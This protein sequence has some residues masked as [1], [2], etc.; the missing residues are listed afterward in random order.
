MNT[1]RFQDPVWLWLLIPVIAIG[2]LSM[3]REKR[4]AVLYSNVNLLRGLPV[5]LAQRLKRFLPWLRI[6]GMVLIVLA[7]A[8]PQS[9]REEFR[10]RTEGIAIEMCI[11]R[12]GSMQALDFPVDGE[13][14]GFEF[15]KRVVCIGSTSI[16]NR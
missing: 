5:T 8:R 16:L 13:N 11:D 6:C 14:N 3:R 1:F 15:I 12:S 7:L 9:G 2:L 4:T 10:I